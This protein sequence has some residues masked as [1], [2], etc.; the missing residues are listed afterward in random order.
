MQPCT[1]THIHTFKIIFLFPKKDRGEVAGSKQA[2]EHEGSQQLPLHSPRRGS[3]GSELPQPWES[4]GKEALLALCLLALRAALHPVGSP[5]CRPGRM[6]GPSTPPVLG[7]PPGTWAGEPATLGA[8]PPVPELG[9]QRLPGPKSPRPCCTAP[10]Q[11]LRGSLWSAAT[12]TKKKTKEK[13]RTGF[14]T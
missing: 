6:R 11:S 3:E 2:E 1:D 8:V 5:R 14:V 4:S 12:K 13:T 7:A 9:T 10:P